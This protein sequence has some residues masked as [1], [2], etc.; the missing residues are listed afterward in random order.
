MTDPYREEAESGT[1]GLTEERWQAI[2]QNDRTYDDHFFYA[3]KT[4]RIFCRPSCKSKAPKK[5]NVRIFRDA[6]QALAANFRPCK[7]CRP[8]GQ[9]LPDNEWVGQITQYIDTNFREAIT[10]ERLADL[11]HGSPYHLHRTFRR[12]QG[13]TPVEYVHQTRITKAKEYLTQTEETI[14]EIADRVGLPNTPYFVT[15][16]K[17]KTGYTPTEYRQINRTQQT[18]EGLRRAINKN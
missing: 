13:M 11:C 18:E 8:T 6:A 3:V 1:E 17:K 12:I 14:S 2:L 4:T 7:R 5:E 9:R 15:L 10:L 16:F